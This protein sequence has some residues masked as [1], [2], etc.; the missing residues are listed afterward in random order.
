[1]EK[2]RRRLL[3]IISVTA[4]WFLAIVW[5]SFNLRALHLLGPYR[6]LLSI[7]CFESIIP[8]F[9]YY[10]MAKRMP[11]QAIGL[12]VL[13]AGLILTSVSG[14]AYFMLHLDNGW[15]HAILN[16]GQGLFALASLIFIW[17]AVKKSRMENKTA[18]KTGS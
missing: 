18:A 6:I 2:Y 8:I 7:L 4:I 15:V 10:R 5:L 9:F 14:V 17:Q 3:I 13:A 1:M 16:W 11:Q 12:A